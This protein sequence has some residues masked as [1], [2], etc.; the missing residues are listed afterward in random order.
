MSK[1]E[2]KNPETEDET[3]TEDAAPEEAGEEADEEASDDDAD[4][5]PKKA[6]S[7]KVKIDF[8]AVMPRNEAVSYFEAIVA[9]L[10]SGRLEFKREGET[11]VLNP[12]EL[13][14]VE[15]K[16]SRKGDK[17]KVVF[18]IEWSDEARGLEI[19]S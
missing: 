18:E 19:V 17:G 1:D 5:E 9:G 6:K 8:E 16:A 2:S 12:P 11:L 3:P 13:L 4:D 15:V 10:A 14:E 7:K